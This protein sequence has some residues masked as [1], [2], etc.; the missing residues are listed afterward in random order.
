MFSVDSMGLGRV[1]YVNFDQNQSYGLEM[2][3]GYR[4]TKW[5]R[6]NSSFNVYSMQEDGS[7]I[8]NYDNFAIWG[9]ANINNNFTLS[10]GWQIQSNIFYRSPLKLVIGQ[11]NAMWRMNFSVSKRIFKN[12]KMCSIG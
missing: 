9:H 4:P 10:K 12:K 6:I 11:I 1:Q 8:G 7:N 5:W 3:A 2:V